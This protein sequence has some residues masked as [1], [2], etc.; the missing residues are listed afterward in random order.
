MLGWPCVDT[1][2]EVERA[3]GLRVVD[4][5]ARDGEAG[6]REREAAALGAACTRSHIVV[7][8]GGGIGERA[9][10]MALMHECGWLVGL[11]ISAETAWQRLQAEAHEA[12][13]PVGEL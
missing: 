2:L 6:F 11:R 10:N 7:A 12:D 3:T 1:D 8:T 9:E 5:F 4:V 13:V